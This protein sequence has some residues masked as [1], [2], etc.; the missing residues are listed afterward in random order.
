MPKYELK[1]IHHL[2]TLALALSIPEEQLN[3]VAIQ[4]NSLYRKAKPVIKSDGSIRQPY[5]ALPPLKEIQQ[6]IKDRILKRVVYPTYL[7]GSL[8]GRTYR[9]NAQLHTQA[10]IVICEDI[11]S[12]FPS[13]NREL[14]RNIWLK[15]FN[16]SEEVAAILCDLTTKDGELPQG[17]STSSYLA[18]LAFWSYE[19]ELNAY[20]A[21]KNITYSR[22]VDDITLSSKKHL[23]KEEQSSLIAQIYGMLKQHGYKAKRR[24][25]EIFSSGKR[26]LTTKLVVNRKASLPHEERQK[27]RAA[28]HALE[29][30]VQDGIRG[31]EVQTEL[32]RVTSRVGQLGL[33]HPREA[34]TLKLRVRKVRSKLSPPQIQKTSALSSRSHSHQETP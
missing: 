13:T 28:V 9:T 33:L 16:F 5:D 29:R 24:K 27:I 8:T 21:R 26:M 6:R 30:T 3:Q 15:F 18:N 19:S 22:Y 23:S 4:A 2:S 32:N 7:T 25:H 14:V 11:Q 20:L 10:K 34:E 1:P 31:T 17:A 12:F